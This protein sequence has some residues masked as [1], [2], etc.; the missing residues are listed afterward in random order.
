VA[1]GVVAVPAATQLALH[2]LL[3]LHHVATL[4]FGGASAGARTLA[5]HAHKL[6]RPNAPG[7]AA[8]NALA[9]GAA[10]PLLAQAVAAATPSRPV[11]RGGVLQWLRERHRRHHGDG[12]LISADAKR[13]A[14]CFKMR[15]GLSRV[16]GLHAR[17]LAFESRAAVRWHMLTFI[18]AHQRPPTSGENWS[19]SMH[20]E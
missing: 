16:H 20:L 17:L 12:G 10:S 5:E 7:V 13:Y 14:T 6:G 2:A 19:S 18:T 1:A 3:A 8:G 9:A 11:T 4:G 15:V